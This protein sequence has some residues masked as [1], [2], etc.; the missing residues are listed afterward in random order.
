MA[1][2]DDGAARRL[3]QRARSAEAEIDALLPR[4]RSPLRASLTAQPPLTIAT[5]HS[6]FLQLL[7]RAPFD[8]GALGNADLVEQ[9]APLIADAWQRFGASMQRAPASAAARGLDALFARY[10]M[11]STRNLLLAFLRRRAD[12][13][14]YTRHLPDPKA[15][16]DYALERMRADIDLDR[17]VC[18]ELFAD[19]SLAA[20]LRSFA[21]LLARNGSLDS[22][23]A[24]RMTAALDLSDLP[25]CFERL[26]PA[27]LTVEG[28]A[29]KRNPSQAQAK[30]LG[31]SDEQRLLQLHTRLT[32]RLLEARRDF[33]DQAS[34][35]VNAAGLPAAVAFL[36]AYRRVKEER[37]VIDFA[38]VECRALEL[39]SSSDHAAFLYYKLDARYRHV[40]L[41][42][43]QDTNPLQWMTLHAWFTAAQEADS[44]PKLFMVGD[45]KQSIYRFRGAEARLF[46]HAS[47][48]LAAHFDADAGL[49]RDE[50]R[51]CAPVVIALVNAVFSADEGFSA[52]T[53]HYAA[54]PG[55]VEVLPLTA[56]DVAAPAAGSGAGPL[57]LRDALTTPFADVEDR[58]REEEA[59][60]LA[61][62]IGSIVGRWVIESDPAG[63]ASR[64]ADF[65]DIMVLVRQRT[66]LAVYERALRAAGI[67][68]VTAGRGGLLDTLE[69]KR[70]DGVAAIPG[71]AICQ[72]AARANA[73]RPAIRMLRR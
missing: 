53:A 24:A 58:R 40:L 20:D 52:H 70:R 11:H 69:A 64:E 35:S 66:H 59:A 27:V 1:I 7:K 6:W 10:G 5:F 39:L 15:G 57:C 31:A 33:A 45:P 72:P 2:A 61:S 23:L 46:G 17:D 68:F 18:G 62:K 67:P 12:W 29:R 56:K 73:A 63:S 54:K 34:Y 14:A 36:E 26:W 48:Y 30:R 65:K 50:S 37:Q 51:R 21:G 71:F 3:L 8:A 44:L 22:G 49:K 32:A 43:F 16:V 4:A 25:A 55:R 41:D 60:Q 13:W 9:T 42:E 38:D 19:G 28:N 47:A